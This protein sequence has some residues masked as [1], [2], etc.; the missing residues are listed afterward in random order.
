MKPANIDEYILKF[1]LDI[2]NKLTQ[3]RSIV[4][5]AAPQAK[6][7]ISY[8]MPAFKLNG[9]LLY[10]A[11]HKNHIGFY[12]YSSAILK[13]KKELTHFKTSTGTIQFPLSQP[14]PLNLITKIVVFRVDEK[15]NI[16]AK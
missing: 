13:F 10:F 5:I 3:I 4:N 9:M 16:S 11:V 8:G 7:I 12:P 14:L 15:L 1:P 6:E 2:Q